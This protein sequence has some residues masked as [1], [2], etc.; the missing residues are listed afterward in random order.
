MLDAGLLELTDDVGDAV[1]S[2]QP[3]QSSGSYCRCGISCGRVEC[4]H[5][6]AEVVNEPVPDLAVEGVTAFVLTRAT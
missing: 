4:P 3:G 2:G 6:K 5:L 1:Q